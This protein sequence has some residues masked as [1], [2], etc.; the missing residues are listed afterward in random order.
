[1][2][3]FID[4]L[5]DYCILYSYTIYYHACLHCTLYS[6]IVIL[7]NYIVKTKVPAGADRTAMSVL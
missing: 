2:L 3:Y 4:Q 5:Y 7:H 6:I 1:M